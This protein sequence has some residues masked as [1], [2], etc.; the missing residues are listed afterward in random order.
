MTR[1]K[2]MKATLLALSIALCVFCSA[3][4]AFGFEGRITTTLTRSGYT[5]TLLYTVGT[6]FLRIENL[7]S[8]HP[9]PRDIVDLSSGQLTLLFPHNRS[10]VH[11]PSADENVSTMPP[12]PPQMASLPPQRM[13]RPIAPGNLPGT[14]NMPALPPGVGP[15][16]GAGAPA[17]PMPMPMPTMPPMPP[18][19]M[20]PIELKATS[21]T[22]NLLGYP[23]ARYEIKQRDEVMEI[24][25][26][27]KLLPFLPYLQN[28]PRRFGPRMMEEQWGGL[29]KSKKL[30][31]LL[32]VLTFQDGAERF[33]FQVTE[34]KEETIDD[35]DGSLSQPPPDYQEIQPLPF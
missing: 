16:S 9:Y 3:P 21:D 22:T 2:T 1:R 8:D 28:Q 33:R 27:E 32:A 24:W 26:T 18:M 6:N 35:K 30:F 15:Q 14:P 19:P 10:Y 31:P 7:E 25:A 13:P 23:C 29:L 4:W 11:L 12:V 17:M 34:I 5:Q 20:Q